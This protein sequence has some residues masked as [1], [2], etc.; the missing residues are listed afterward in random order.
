MKRQIN[1]TGIEV[2][3]IGL[4]GMP[5]SIQ[6]RPDET[7]AF[8]VIEAFVAAGGDFIDTANA[9]CL[10]DKDMGHNE[11][12]IHKALSKIGK[13]DRVTVATKGGLTR[14]KGRWEVDGR[15]AW[16]R[17][18]CEKSL[19]DLQTD[20]ITLYQLHAVDTKV[21]LGESLGEL[22]RLKEEG[23]IRHIGL[24]NVKPNQLES[25]VRQT[26]IASVQ[27]S[28][29][30]LHKTDFKNGL[31]DLCERLGITY[32]PYGP[33]G[34]HQGHVRLPK[35]SIMCELAEKYET[36]CYCISLAW[37][38]Q[39]GGHI[40]PIPGASKVSSVHDSARAL[41]VHLESMDMEK[42][43]QIADQ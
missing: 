1:R 18:S 31:I 9:Y 4:G 24:S 39:K 32:I 20:T 40:L 5:L 12:L 14:P 42:I 2:S 26:D 25:A 35:H 38:L 10:D 15:P 3:A 21:P 29:N 17:Q 28:C 33:V 16:L 7:Q 36:S 22:T 34:G 19:S 6:G 43:D 8:Q 41:S 37:L 11:A 30:P 13:R 27:N 23:K